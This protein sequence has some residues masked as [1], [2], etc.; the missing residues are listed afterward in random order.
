M[1]CLSDGRCLFLSS[2][3]VRSRASAH[4]RTPLRKSTT[5]LR[6]DR[7][8]EIRRKVLLLPEIPHHIANKRHCNEAPT[9]QSPPRD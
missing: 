9:R 5:S 7:M 8:P 1:S 2:T 6:D 3:P 4:P